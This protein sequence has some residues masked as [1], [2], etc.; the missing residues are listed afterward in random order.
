MFD[1]NFKLRYT[2]IPFAVYCGDYRK[3][4]QPSDR[5][6]LHHQHSEVEILTVLDGDAVLYADNNTYNLTCGD[7]VVISPYMLHSY[8]IFAGK[9]F[10]HYCLCFD[11]SLLCDTDIIPK[12]DNDIIQIHTHIKHT[13]EIS[14]K[15]SEYAANAYHA[16]NNKNK[17][18]ELF[19][20]GNMMLFF[21]ILKSENKI[22]KA[23]KNDSDFCRRIIEFIS[24][25]YPHNITSADAA[26]ALYISNS[27]FCRVFKENFGCCFQDYLAMYRIE[28]SKTLLK[29]TNK[30][31]SEI[32]ADT[33]FNS[34]SYYSKIFK[35]YNLCTPREYRKL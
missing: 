16:C 33:G 26:K 13:D 19:A 8:K 23:V 10:Y 18:W 3:T 29:L 5:I 30:T 9:P 31:I 15:L 25:N 6:A 35:K 27:Y 28:K 24:N 1:D 7:V 12:S 21:G 22:K 20:I 4:P 17:G 2:T 32:S 14:K 11:L 34:F